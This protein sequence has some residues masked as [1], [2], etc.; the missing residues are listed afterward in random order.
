M[1]E[2]NPLVLLNYLVNPKGFLVHFAPFQQPAGLALRKVSQGYQN[3]A[4]VLIGGEVLKF[5]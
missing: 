2:L 5:Q 4:L 3:R 1:P